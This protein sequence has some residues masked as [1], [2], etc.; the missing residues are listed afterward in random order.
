VTM[1]QAEIFQ[2]AYKSFDKW[3]KL[4][5]Q[6]SG[7]LSLND[8]SELAK[9]ASRLNTPFHEVVASRGILT[10]QWLLRSAEKVMVCQVV[11]LEDFQ[12]DQEAFSLLPREFME[13]NMALP[14]SIDRDGR[15]LILALADPYNLTVTDE[16]RALTKLS[17]TPVFALATQIRGVLIANP[18]GSD[19]NSLVE[20]MRSLSVDVEDS[21]EDNIEVFSSN[22]A[23]EPFVV[24]ITNSILSDA[25]AS[26]ASDI[27]IEP[28]EN[29]V[30][31]RMRVDGMLV[32]KINRIEKQYALPIVSRI[33]ILSRLNIAEHRRPQDGRF[34]VKAG[35]MS[36]DFRVST[37]PTQFGEKIV[38]RLSNK[39]VAISSLSS[40]G[41]ENEEEKFLKKMAENPYG[42]ILATG[43]TGSGKSTT[44]YGLLNYLNSPYKNII[45]IEDPIERQI[46]GVIQTAVDTKAGM[47]FTTGLKTILRQD[48]DTIMVGEIRDHD[49]AEMAM[50]AAL[51]GH[52]VLSTLHTNDAAGAITRLI[53]MGVE[54][55]KVPSALLA[56]IA[57]RLVR[58]I[59]P[60]CKESYPPSLE[61]LYLMESISPAVKGTE[62][63]KLYRGAGCRKCGNTGF[64]GREGIFEMLEMSDEIKA[65]TM[66][67][68]STNTIKENAVLRGMKTMETR[69]VEKVLLGVTTLSEVRRVVFVK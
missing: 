30:R 60:H 9:E 20:E 5:L 4:Y 67:R 15:K 36:I 26:E 6:T 23:D 25:V 62:I 34:K 37:M 47:T 64:K 61:E 43:P 40:L 59:C 13:K 35:D 44:L 12:V 14:L 50:Q 54:P 32:E 51:T 16:A 17:I 65:L 55:F 53:D 7:D 2:K 10:P 21:G 57:Q 31:V 28:M 1:N 3:L 22:S 41:F 52:L 8:A 24:R 18:A 42:L 46:F 29:H 11:D 45:T 33:K 27:H 56:V 68:V 58:K 19:M 66:Q 38:M 49:T 48:P 39:S 63:K 69:G